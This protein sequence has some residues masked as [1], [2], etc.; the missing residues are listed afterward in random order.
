M[1]LVTALHTPD[2]QVS[3][4]PEQLM[5]AFLLFAQMS[6]LAS[7]AG[8]GSVPTVSEEGSSGSG[9]SPEPVH[10]DLG[11]LQH[12]KNRVGPELRLMRQA[13]GRHRCYA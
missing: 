9:R 3:S 1:P 13:Q 12:Y 6:A 5:L 4:Q 2:L 11:S 10:V 8:F 7:S